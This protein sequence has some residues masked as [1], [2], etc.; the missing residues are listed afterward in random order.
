MLAL[1]GRAGVLKEAYFADGQ[2]QFVNSNVAS[3]RLGKFLLERRALT[4]QALQRARLGDA[5]LRRPARRHAR[6]SR[7]LDPLEAYRL[8]AKQVGAKLMEAFSWQKGRYTWTPR[9]P[10]PVQVA[11]A[12]PRCVPRDRRGRAQLDPDLVDDWARNNQAPRRRTARRT[13]RA[14]DFGLGEAPSRVYGLL[15]GRTRLGDI[16][17]PRRARPRRGST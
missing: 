2:P 10:E 12:A 15:D 4:R 14:P 13:R 7:L 5:P 8:L 1:E 9:P 11:L 16:V 3:E 17:A 6:R